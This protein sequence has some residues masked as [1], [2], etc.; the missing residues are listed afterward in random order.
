MSNPNPYVDPAENAFEAGYDKGYQ[1]CRSEM[2]MKI[3]AILRC[4]IYSK[5]F[6]SAFELSNQIG[7]VLD[8]KVVVD[9]K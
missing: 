2:S 4:Y 5:K 8:G 6:M 1:D 9:G 3:K 7:N